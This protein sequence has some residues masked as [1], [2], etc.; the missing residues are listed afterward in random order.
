MSAFALRPMT[1]ADVPAAH[2]IEERLFPVDAWSEG[3]FQSELT[4]DTRTYL[5]AADD[6]SR[7][8]GYAGIMVIGTVADLQTIAVDERWQGRGV[9]SALL[10]ALIDDAVARGCVE[11][12]LEVRSDNPAQAVYEHYGFVRIDVRRDYYARG[13]DAF[14]MRKSDLRDLPEATR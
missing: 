13:I 9:G 8:I 1:L 11:M 2:V 7:V 12:F 6:T 10:R 3:L 5:V 14:V 4:Q